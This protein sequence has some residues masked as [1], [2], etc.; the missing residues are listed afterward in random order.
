MTQNY[1]PIFCPQ[2]TGEEVQFRKSYVYPEKYKIL[3][4]IFKGIQE[5]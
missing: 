2:W 4:V 1:L 5:I 3:Q